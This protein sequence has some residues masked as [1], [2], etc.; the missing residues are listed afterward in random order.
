MTAPDESHALAMVSQLVSLL[1]DQIICAENGQF[2]RVENLLGEASALAREVVETRAFDF[3]TC[4]AW[5]DKI[6]ERYQ[7][8]ELILTSAK[9]ITEGELKHANNTLRILAVYRS[10]NR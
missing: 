3:R 10:S 8:L 9:A 1:D 7:R 2:E 6:S 4:Q 5:Q